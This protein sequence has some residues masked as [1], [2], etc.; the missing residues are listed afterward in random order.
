[1]PLVSVTRQTPAFWLGTCTITLCSVN[2][3]DLPN[4]VRISYNI[5]GKT[6]RKVSLYLPQHFIPTNQS[7]SIKKNC[8]NSAFFSLHNTL[9]NT[10]DV[11]NKMLIVH[12]LVDITDFPE[13]KFTYPYLP[14]HSAF[15]RIFPHLNNVFCIHLKI[16]RN[17]NK[18][19]TKGC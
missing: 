14:T 7:S 4:H 5:L 9:R 3:W 1:M 19:P 2:V 16:L 13:A 15:C 17:H 11:T 8:F 18:F 6:K 12:L 10:L